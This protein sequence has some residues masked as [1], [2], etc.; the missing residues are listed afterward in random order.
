MKN[1]VRQIVQ[2]TKDPVASIKKVSK[3]LRLVWK[4]ELQLAQ[5][6][7]PFVTNLA[8][9]ADPTPR[10]KWYSSH[11]PEQ[12][13]T[14]VRSMLDGLKQRGGIYSD[15]AEDDLRAE[16]KVGPQG[17]HPAI[18]S[19][20]PKILEYFGVYGEQDGKD[21]HPDLDIQN[22]TF[23]SAEW[24][25]AKKKAITMLHFSR[26]LRPMS[27]RRV[28][29][30]LKN[31]QKLISNCGFLPGVSFRRR[32]NPEVIDACLQHQS[33][34]L[35]KQPAI[36]GERSTRGKTR[37][38]F[39]T[40]FATNVHGAAYSMVVQDA[41]R[42]LNLPAFSAWEGNEHVRHAMTAM[43]IGNKGVDSREKLD[44]GG[45]T[46]LSSDFTGMDQRFNKK[47]MLETY[48]VLKYAFQ[49]QY[50]KELREIIEYI[51]DT[52]IIFPLED[53]SLRESIAEHSLI[54]GSEWTNL[55]ETVF[56]FIMWIYAKATNCLVQGDDGCVIV[57]WNKDE[58]A[59]VFSDLCFKVGMTGNADKQLVS[60]TKAHYLQRYY[61]KQ[62][63]V[64]ASDGTMELGGVYPVM[65]AF[66]SLLF[67]ER[68]HDPRKWSKE[69]LTIRNLMIT[70][71]TCDHPLFGEF[72]EFV[73]KGDKYLKDFLQL[74]RKRLE[75]YENIARSIP[76]FVPSYNQESKNKRIWQ[77]KTYQVWAAMK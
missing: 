56:A 5:G 22:M 27:H 9:P 32:N 60:D 64:R 36:L 70:E 15:I 26:R 37:L 58:C 74:S 63:Q 12:L 73:G 39:M 14:Q 17:G 61:Y 46:I 67:P 21:R 31:D 29:D 4:K 48:D 77:F 71:N 33:G 20:Y 1:T 2:L 72:A 49:E 57:P 6:F 19:L 51:A 35:W 69:M 44:Q 75:A 66:N 28:V 47:C 68:Y 10:S 59:N 62:Y 65:L 38:I 54:S 42:K 11:S 25:D 55:L 52:P 40:S 41:I 8:R 76:G 24:A 13:T 18:S 53:G 50:W 43:L 30:L 7:T 16:S 34:E 3:P 45:A 23:S